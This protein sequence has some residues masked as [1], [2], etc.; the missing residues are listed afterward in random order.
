MDSRSEIL[1]VASELLSRYPKLRSGVSTR[2][3]GVSPEP[4]G[5]NLSYKV[6]DE[7]GHV[8]ENRKLF[9]GRLGISIRDLAIPGQVH[10]D[11]VVIVH[12]PGHYPASDG[13]ISHRP[14]VFLVLTVADCLPVL[15][16]DPRT[17]TVSAVHAGWRGSRSGILNKALRLMASE[18][19]VR[20]R[21]LIAFL[22]PCAGVCCYQVGEDVAAQF[23]PRYVQKRGGKLFLNIRGINHDILLGAGVPET[24]IE[25]SDGCTICGTPLFHSYRR[26]GER[27]GR[28]M[29]VI[30]LEE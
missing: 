16:F 7:Q 10:G 22:G 11:T 23:P 1:V 6:G 9:F 5:M 26:D 18:R 20:S 12:K 30:G 17:E 4:F 8:E 24:N 29:A 19:G 28:M 15:L 3:G 25:N 21:D 13:L 14:G 27:S 2:T